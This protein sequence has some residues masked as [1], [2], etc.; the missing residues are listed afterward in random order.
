MPLII[1]LLAGFVAP[2]SAV[3]AYSVM[4]PRTFGLNHRPTMLN[5]V[6]I[7]SGNSYIA[8]YWSLI[9]A[10]LTVV[11][12]ALV[13]YPIAYGMA[14]VFGRWS[15]VIVLLFT[16]PLFVSENVRLYGWILFF[17]KNG[18]LLGSLKSVSGIEP[19]SWLF[20]KGMVLLGMVYVY[21]PFMLFPMSLGVAMVPG[22]AREAA[23]DLGRV[24]GRCFERSSCRCRCQASS[25]DCS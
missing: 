13:C 1:V 12:L 3:V 20:T 2:L 9:F 23:Q 22:D 14:R 6:E 5:Y 21:L 10:V 18:V 25:S 7:F 11:I 24:A 17:I 4:P 8:L 16:I 15:T 19:D